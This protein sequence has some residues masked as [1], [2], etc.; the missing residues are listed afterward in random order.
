MFKPTHAH[1]TQA[2]QPG[3]AA[4]VFSLPS[5]PR[6]TT[7]TATRGGA[8]AGAQTAS[9]RRT[10]RT[11]CPPPPTRTPHAPPSND[12]RPNANKHS[13]R[14]LP[15]QWGES[16][17]PFVVIDFSTED[18]VVGSATTGDRGT[19]AGGRGGRVHPTTPAG[20]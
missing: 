8:A 5:Q 6:P 7:T 10:P 9:P 3:P 2:Q 12:P 11:P 4:P 18:V 17:L 16:A 14:T 13:N 19:R 15:G 1:F 20:C